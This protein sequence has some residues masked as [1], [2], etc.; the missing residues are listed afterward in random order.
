MFQVDN[1]LDLPRDVIHRELLG[2]L[3]GRKRLIVENYKRLLLFLPEEIKIQCCTC[4]MTVRGEKLRITYFNQ[5][6]MMIEG[7]IHEISFL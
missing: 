7:E 4:F 1:A 6:A 3:V 5:E 2:Q